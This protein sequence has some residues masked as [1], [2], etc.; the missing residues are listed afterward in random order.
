M[1]K[2][3][4]WIL[5][6]MLAIAMPEAEVKIIDDILSH[7]DLNENV[8]LS[9]EHKKMMQR[10]FKNERRKTFYGRLIH[11]TKRGAAVFIIFFLIF[12]VLTVSV[13]AWRIKVLNF[14]I[15]SNDISTLI[16]LSGN[17]DSY[18]DITIEYIRSYMTEDTTIEHMLRGYSLEQSEIEGS[19]ISLTFVKDNDYFK[20]IRDNINSNILIDTENASTKNLKIN[21]N[22]AFFSTNGNVS[23]LIWHDNYF[24]Y[25]LFG[26]ISEYELCLIA[27]K[28]K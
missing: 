13:D 1:N 18:D 28:I 17:K 9:I 15:S 6:S 2:L 23:H 19:Y 20:F 14:V 3:T 10:L 8:V 22:E 26:T 27:E 4:N 21:N 12:A 11:Y 24:V 16:Q 5:D 7:I 25:S